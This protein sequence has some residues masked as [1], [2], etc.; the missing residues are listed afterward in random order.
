MDFLEFLVQKLWQNK[1]KLIREI[2]WNYSAMSSMIWVF[3]P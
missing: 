1:H 3:W 2:H